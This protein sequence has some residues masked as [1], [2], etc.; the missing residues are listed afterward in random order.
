MKP[1]LLLENVP[2][3]PTYPCPQREPETSNKIVSVSYA[4]LNLILY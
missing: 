4:N 1:T 2:C 3:I